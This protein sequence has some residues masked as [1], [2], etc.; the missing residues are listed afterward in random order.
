MND[1]SKNQEWM[2]YE[3]VKLGRQLDGIDQNIKRLADRSDLYEAIEMAVHENLQ[4]LLQGVMQS[5]YSTVTVT[6]LLSR[7]TNSR[8][9][10]RTD[11]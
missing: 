9:V 5:T 6:V 11:D 7:Y 4:P 2:S 8:C 3:T 1:M 10:I